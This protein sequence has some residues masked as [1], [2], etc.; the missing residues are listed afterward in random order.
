MHEQPI[1]M[2]DT[3]TMEHAGEAG[4]EFYAGLEGPILAD[5]RSDGSMQ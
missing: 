5:N 1:S 3:V 4:Q 2:L